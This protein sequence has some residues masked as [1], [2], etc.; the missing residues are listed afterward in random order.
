MMGY[1]YGGGGGWIAM[2]AMMLMVWGSLA[3]LVVWAVLTQRRDRREPGQVLADRFARGEITEDEFARSR[4][5]L[6]GAGHRP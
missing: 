5:V 6:T 3:G 1:H 2:S 4:D